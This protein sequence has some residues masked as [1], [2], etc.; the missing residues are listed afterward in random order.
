ME[1]LPG[2][3]WFLEHLSLCANN[4]WAQFQAQSKCS[5]NFSDFVI[6]KKKPRANQLLGR[7][8]AQGWLEQYKQEETPHKCCCCSS[9]KSCPTLCGP[10]DYSTPGFPV[11]Y[12]LPEF[13]Q[14]HVHW[15][16]DL[17]QTSHPQL[18]PLLLPSIFPSIRIFSDE[19]VLCI[20]WPKYFSFSF[21]ISP[22]N[23]YSGLISSRIDWFD[24][25]AIQWDSPKLK[26]GK[27][28]HSWIVEISNK[29]IY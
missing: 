4:L 16:S 27:Q 25:L 7:L 20:R 23:E 2:L 8:F 9:R 10:M 6:I 26:P 18:P 15:V 11:P 21:S 17:I 1:L 22:S 5:A 24:L 12:Y 28:Y 29:S 19:L 3:R 14:T 13:A